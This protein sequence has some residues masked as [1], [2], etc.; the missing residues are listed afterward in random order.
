VSAYYLVEIKHT[1]S[2][3]N[4]N[5]WY[6]FW[7]YYPYFYLNEK[8]RRSL[9]SLWHHQLLLCLQYWKKVKFKIWWAVL[10]ENR[11]SQF[12]A[13][14]DNSQLCC[15]KIC[16]HKFLPISLLSLRNR[17]TFTLWTHQGRRRTGTQCGVA[18]VIFLERVQWGVETSFYKQQR[19]SFLTQAVSTS[20]DF[21]ATFLA[22]KTFEMIRSMIFY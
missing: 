18:L 2:G 1:Y 10:V 14:K 15:R 4:S 9:W 3:D 7:S 21:I 22:S 13:K 16:S 12:R 20:F 17:L 8:Q 19:K 11:W 6:F 5:K